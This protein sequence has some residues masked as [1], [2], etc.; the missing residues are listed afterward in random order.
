MLF[1]C[2]VCFVMLCEPCTLSVQSWERFPQH[3]QEI[4]EHGQVR[5]ACMSH[6]K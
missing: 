5:G 2:F 6:G 3:K 1:V 4:L